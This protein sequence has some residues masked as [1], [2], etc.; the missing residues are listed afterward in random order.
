MQYTCG[1]CICVSTNPGS[2]NPPWRT[3]VH[4]VNSWGSVEYGPQ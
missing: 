1:K 3:S 2:R 4:E